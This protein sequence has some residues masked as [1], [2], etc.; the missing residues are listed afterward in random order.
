[1]THKYIP[2]VYL[3]GWSKL[4]KWYYGSRVAQKS[5][6]LYKS[7]CH[8]D[9]LFVTYF[10]SSDYVKNFVNDNGVPD[11]IQ[12]RKTFDDP[13]L[14]RKWES[15]VILRMNLKESE[16]WLNK[17]NSMGDYVMDSEVQKRR[18]ERCKQVLT[19]KKRSQEI[20]DKISQS[21]KGKSF[22][23]SHKQALKAASP[24][25]SKPCSIETKQKISERTKGKIVSDESREKMSLAAKGKIRWETGRSLSTIN[26]IKDTWL[27][28]ELIKCPH[29]DVRSKSM[30]SLVRWHFDNCKH[31]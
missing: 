13:K 22:S 29:C 24:H 19:G 16:K 4:N 8:P 21:K 14:A 3:I 25:I 1:M 9:E 28:K 27:N 6:C 30:S 23:D 11:I 17:G 7:G 20:G 31:K 15:S 10:T 12:I 18:I 5:F 26:K 2:Y